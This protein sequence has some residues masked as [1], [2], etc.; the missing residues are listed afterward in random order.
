ME[1]VVSMPSGDGPVLL[2]G[3]CVGEIIGGVYRTER[4]TRD[5]YCVKHQGWG[6]QES[7]YERLLARRLRTKMIEYIQVTS[8]GKYGNIVYIS[9][10]AAWVK[11][12][13]RDTL[14][15]KDGR[16][17]FLHKNHFRKKE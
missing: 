3:K 12:G 7:I 4:D 17:I 11:F 13:V 5:G 2:N 1:E 16:Q 15:E 9:D 8:A 6:V 14:R 10:I